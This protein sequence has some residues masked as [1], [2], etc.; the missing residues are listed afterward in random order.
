LEL[1]CPLCHNRMTGYT[2]TDPRSPFGKAKATCTFCG[3]GY[4]MRDDRAIAL[5]A[6]KPIQAP[7][8][9][10]PQPLRNARPVSL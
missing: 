8:S 10:A 7:S 9:S 4:G 6:Q 5:L 1:Q 2:Y 3:I